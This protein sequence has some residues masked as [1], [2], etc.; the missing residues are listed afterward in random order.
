MN[1]ESKNLISL[2]VNQS[3]GRERLDLIVGMRGLSQTG[4]SRMT[5]A[6]PGGDLLDDTPAGSHHH[7]TPHPCFQSKVF[8]LNRVQLTSQTGGNC[9]RTGEVL[10]LI[11]D[12]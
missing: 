11:S 2:D 10:G 4:E 7:L 8:S 1:P 12:S 3:H 5:L 9:A 6:P